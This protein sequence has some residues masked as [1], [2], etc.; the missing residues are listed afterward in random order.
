M[1]GKLSGKKLYIIIGS[2]ILALLILFVVLLCI[3][4]NKNKSDKSKVSGKVTDS[5]MVDESSD[6]ESSEDDSS[7]TVDSKIDSSSLLDSSSAVVT[8]VQ[9]KT[10]TPTSPS[11]GSTTTTGGN[12]TKTTPGVTP[13]PVETSMTISLQSFTP[14]AERNINTGLGMPVFEYIFG[15]QTT[16]NGIPTKCI[17][18]RDTV[19]LTTSQ[20]VT[21]LDFDSNLI[22]ATY[23]GNTI[24]V[25]A[26]NLGYKQFPDQTYITVN[27]KYK[28]MLKVYFSFSYFYSDCLDDV[29]YIYWIGRGRN[30]HSKNDIDITYTN[31]DVNKSITKRIAKYG[32]LIYDDTITYNDPSSVKQVMDLLDEYVR[33]GYTTLRCGPTNVISDTMYGACK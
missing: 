31:G 13:A 10:K 27:G 25:T 8:D 22:N 28:Y 6:S 32:E 29:A 9:G 30:F 23:S 17:Q 19:V 18:Q 16:E 33:R 11:G 7:S 20:P 1:F 24:T 3:N 5:S 2:V 12:T 21:S 26:N 15:K 4:K 14:Y